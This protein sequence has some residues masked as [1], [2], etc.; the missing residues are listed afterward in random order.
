MG[1]DKSQKRPN[2][3]SKNIMSKE[4]RDSLKTIPEIEMWLDSA[5]GKSFV[6]E[7]NQQASLIEA[8]FKKLEQLDDPNIINMPM[9]I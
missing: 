2:E 6:E 3:I 8:D 7:A 5:D 1:K 9:A 4:F